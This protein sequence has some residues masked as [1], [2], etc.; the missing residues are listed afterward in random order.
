ML[1]TFALS[2]ALVYAPETIT[3]IAKGDTVIVI[4]LPL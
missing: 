3:K 4:Q 2:N 1:Q